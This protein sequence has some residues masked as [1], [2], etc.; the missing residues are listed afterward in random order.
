MT[1]KVKLRQKP[2]SGK[3][4]SLY[5]DFYP[6]ILHPKTGKLTRRDFL[7][8]Y[9]FDD[10]KNPIDKLH[11]KEMLKLAKQIRQ[12]WHNELNSSEVLTELNKKQLEKILKEEEEEAKKKELEERDFL[13]YFRNLA[14]KRKTTN[15][16]N[17]ISTYKY[18]EAYAGGNLK[19]GDLNKQYCNNFKDYLLNAK[20]IRSNRINLSQNSAVSYFNKFKAALKQAYSDGCLSSDLNAVVECIPTQD[21]IKQTL[22]LEEL[23]KLAQTECDSPLLKQVVL[24]AALT[25]MPFKE[26][27]NLQWGQIEVSETF[28]VQVKMIRQKTGRLYQINISEQAYTLLGERKEPTEKVFENLSNRDRYHFFPLWLATAG[29]KKKLTFHKLRDTYGC[30]QIDFGTDIYTLKDNMGHSQISQTMAYAKA[31]RQKKRD[32]AEVVKLD[33]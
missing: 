22:T 12:K 18:L 6:A 3:R 33:L 16:D 10:D 17:W 11:N 7:G 19:F 15:H 25:G 5:L 30:L 4:Q 28:G 8:L 27:Q 26:L 14:D 1:I 9:L 24:F 31:S 32:A 20:S 29:I 13:E 21:T 23:N 2:I